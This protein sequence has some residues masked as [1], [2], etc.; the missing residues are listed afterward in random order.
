M[1]RGGYITIIVCFLSMLVYQNYQNEKNTDNLLSAY[2]EVF[3]A[4]KV[5]SNQDTTQLEIN[6]IKDSLSDLT[7][8]ISSTPKSSDTIIKKTYVKNIYVTPSVESR[9]SAEEETLMLTKSD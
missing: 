2:K 3:S 9:I 4:E 1:S 7:K 5:N 6:S 8:L